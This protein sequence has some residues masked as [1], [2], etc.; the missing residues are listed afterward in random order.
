MLTLIVISADQTFLQFFLLLLYNYL[1]S[2][3]LSHC[4]TISTVSYIWNLNSSLTPLWSPE[5]SFDL[6]FLKEMKIGPTF[7][8][9]IIKKAFFSVSL[10][11][12]IILLLTDKNGHLIH[13]SC[14]LSV[15][16]TLWK[17]SWTFKAFTN[18]FHQVSVIAII[19]QKT[20]P[21]GTRICCLST[22]RLTLRLNPVEGWQKKKKKK[23][24]APLRKS[25]GQG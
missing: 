25:Q 5:F 1:P 7:L 8:L 3:A 24:V 12:I 13:M 22:W 18:K 23:I 19:L 16:D 10:E 11:N 21:M 15:M 14:N 20:E 6:H 4:P 17:I 9:H 2:P